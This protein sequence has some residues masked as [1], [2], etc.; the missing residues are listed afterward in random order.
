MGQEF[1]VSTKSGVDLKTYES[2]TVVKGDVLTAEDRQIDEDAFFTEIKTAIVREMEVRGYKFVDDPTAQLAVSYVVE[3]TMKFESQRLG[4]LGQTPITNPANVDAS[5]N[6]SKE[7]RQG[8][9]IIDM[10]D[11]SKKSSVWSAEGV[12]DITRSRGGNI[13]DYA[14]RMAFKKFPDKTKK[15]KKSKK[16]KG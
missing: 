13:V 9:L 8:S 11:S 5:P 7:F 3:T 10:V 4:P 16:S 14:V 6:W 2:F 12:M 1:T 15:E